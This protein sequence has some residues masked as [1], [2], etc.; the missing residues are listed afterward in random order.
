MDYFT[1]LREGHALVR[2]MRR[3]ANIA[4]KAPLYTYVEGVW[5]VDEDGTDMEPEPN[6]GPHADYA[7]AEAHAWA[8][9]VAA[10][11]LRAWGH[12]QDAKFIC[13]GDVLEYLPSY[14]EAR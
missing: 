10:S 6:D 4:R 8:H 7:E 11:I 9:P 2:D 5:S 12:D 1:Q 13:Y 14:G 3:L